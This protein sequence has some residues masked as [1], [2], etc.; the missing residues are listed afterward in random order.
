[1]AVP[2]DLLRTR[3]DFLHQLLHLQDLGDDLA[4]LAHQPFDLVATQLLNL[5]PQLLRL[6]REVVQAADLVLEQVQLLI[7]PFQQGASAL[8]L[9]LLATTRT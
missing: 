5:Q 9:K 8:D 7:L 1:M 3:G 4:A 6:V 2:R